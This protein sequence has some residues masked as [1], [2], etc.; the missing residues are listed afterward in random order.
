MSKVENVER[1]NIESVKNRLSRFAMCL[2]LLLTDDTTGCLYR[3]VEK[4]N[5]NSVFNTFDIF[6]LTFFTF[7][8]FPFGRFYK[9][10]YPSF[11]KYKLHFLQHLASVYLVE[12][13]THYT[14]MSYILWSNPGQGSKSFR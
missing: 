2:K 13:I 7:D 6:L 14:I 5:L 8:I 11:S 12:R 1:K 9:S 4:P 10:R 3:I